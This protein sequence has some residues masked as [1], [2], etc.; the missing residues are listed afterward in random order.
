MNNSN[1]IFIIHKFSVKCFHLPRFLSLCPCVWILLA[2]GSHT[3]HTNTQTHRYTN[4]HVLRHGFSAK[5]SIHIHN[6]MFKRSFSTKS[7]TTTTRKKINARTFLVEKTYTWNL[8]VFESEHNIS[9]FTMFYQSNCSTI[10]AIESPPIGFVRINSLALSTSVLRLIYAFF[11]FFSTCVQILI[12]KNN[13]LWIQPEIV[14]ET[15]D[16]WF[17][18][19]KVKCN[20]K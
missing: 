16:I 2:F 18:S 19:I 1:W 5:P 8:A 10:L 13:L 17:G 7:T 4:T 12:K 11:G 15:T 14:V 3:P 20:P 6:K 9:S